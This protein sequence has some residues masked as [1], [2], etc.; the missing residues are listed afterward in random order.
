MENFVRPF[1]ALRPSQKYAAAVIA[2]PYDVISESEARALVRDHPHCFLRISRPEVDFPPDT[3]P[4]S[5][6]VYAKGAENLERLRRLGI[7]V[8]DPKPAYYIY[9]I[10]T[11]NHQQTGI[12]LTASVRAYDTNRIRKHELTTPAKENDRVRNIEILNAQ[13]GPVLSVYKADEKIKQLLKTSK[14]N[15]P[16][17]ENIAQQGTTHT[18]WRIDNAD[19]LTAMSQAFDAMETI[20]IADGH[21]RS[22]AASKVSARRRAENPEASK[23]ASHEYFLTVAFPHN[24]LKILNYNRVVK[25]L[26]GLSPKELLKKLSV[27]FD[28][29]TSENPVRPDSPTSYG[30]Y[31]Y[32]RW[33]QLRI[34]DN[35]KTE[36]PSAGLDIT[37]LQ[38]HLIEPL[39]GIDDPRTDPRIDFIG[40]IQG[41]DKL[42]ELVDSGQWAVAF[43]LHPTSMDQLMAVADA[44]ELMP[45]KSTWFEPKLADGLLSHLLD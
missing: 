22:A 18:V 33:Y 35:L 40:G 1:A 37:L 30:M 9:Q 6:A 19:T 13:T 2:P 16:L 15:A 39:L 3:N 26:N 43:A 12:A 44:E 20:Y 41:Q 14:A 28:V 10:Q 5:D 34:H 8:H 21:H 7:L 17:F 38:K 25:N 36:D 24:E 27:C 32:G 4:Y 23:H 31:L 29:D 11:D 45:P 42:K